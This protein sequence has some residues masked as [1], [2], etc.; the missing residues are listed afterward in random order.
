MIIYGKYCRP[1]CCIFDYHR[2]VKKRIF[3]IDGLIY[4]VAGLFFKFAL[5]FVNINDFINLSNVLSRVSQVIYSFLA[6][7]MF[8][9]VSFSLLQWLVDP[10]KMADKELGAKK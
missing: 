1:W 2:F 5:E 6:I 3:I 10:D 7:F 4:G 9:R 8:F